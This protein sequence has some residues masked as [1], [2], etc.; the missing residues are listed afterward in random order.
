MF[1]AFVVFVAFVLVD[2][3]LALP[4]VFATVRR[5]AAVTGRR[6]PATAS[7]GVDGLD[8]DEEIPIVQMRSIINRRLLLRR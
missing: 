2:V 1:V 5:G 7:R 6:K 4:V 8:F 3:S